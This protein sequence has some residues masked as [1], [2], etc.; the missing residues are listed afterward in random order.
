MGG[1]G[2]CG[3]G[4]GFL[5]LPFLRSPFST[6]K[7][8][9]SGRD[10]VSCGRR[11]WVYGSPFDRDTL[12]RYCTDPAERARFLPSSGYTHGGAARPI[13]FSRMVLSSVRSFLGHLPTAG[14]VS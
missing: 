2:G 1:G 4:R 13:Y 6:E 8:K 3:W 14:G 10:C 11:S 5:V 9:V 7:K 12:L